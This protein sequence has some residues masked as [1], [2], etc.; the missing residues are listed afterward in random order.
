MQGIGIE[1]S[2]FKDIVRGGKTIEE[3]LGKPKYLK[4]RVGDI[5][6]IREDIFEGDT[7]KKSIPDSARI[8][9]T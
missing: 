6:S 9:N 8:I 2:I 3:R 7:I 1:S 5:L 4:I